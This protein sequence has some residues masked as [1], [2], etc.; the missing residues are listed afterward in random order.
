MYNE[1]IPAK[2]NQDYKNKQ[3]CNPADILLT[4]FNSNR[5]CKSISPD[6]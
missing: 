4:A 3:R 5:F 2:L 6:N 1:E